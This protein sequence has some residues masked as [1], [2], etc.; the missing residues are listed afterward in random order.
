EFDDPSFLSLYGEKHGDEQTLEL[1]LEGVHC[2]ACVWLVEKL[3]ELVPGVTSCRLAF[4][5][6]LARVSFRDAP[7]ADAA[8]AVATG[9]ATAPAPASAGPERTLPSRIAQTL[10][11]LGYPPHPHREGE[12]ALVQRRE[13]RDLLVRLGVAGASAG[14]SM[15][16]AVAL[17]SGGFADM[18]AEHMRYFRV[19]SALVALPAV[20]WSAQVFYRGALGALRARRPHMDL[21]LSIGLSFGVVWG[22]VNLLRDTGEVYFDSLS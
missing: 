20:L 14:N 17:Y 19:L 4:A 5:Q 7:A 16:F 1:L 8:G 18:D 12:R 22:S 6:R 13:E 21:P 11:R 10:D 9:P 15:L 3:P 2:A